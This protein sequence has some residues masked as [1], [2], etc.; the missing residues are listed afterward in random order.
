MADGAESSR[1]VRAFV[2]YYKMCGQI[3]YGWPVAC[4]TLDS[5]ALEWEIEI[6]VPP[7][8]PFSSAT[9]SRLATARAN[10]DEARSSVIVPR[11]S[12]SVSPGFCDSAMG[13]DNFAAVRSPRATGFGRI[14]A[15][16]PD[17]ATGFSP[18][19]PVLSAWVTGPGTIRAVIE[20]RGTVP[21]SIGTAQRSVRPARG[22]FH[23]ARQYTRGMPGPFRAAK[24]RFSDLFL[25]VFK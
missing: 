21:G 2:T 19:Y 25:N 10:A 11:A 5:L 24:P 1:R 23:P 18:V 12:V 22:L 6:G 8:L 7:F 13:F 20:G 16:L 4:A 9:E 17:G 14:H 3:A 15:V